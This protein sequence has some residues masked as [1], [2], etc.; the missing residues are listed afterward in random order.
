MNQ[1]IATITVEI[2]GKKVFETFRGPYKLIIYRRK[3]LL[4]I[5]LWYIIRDFHIW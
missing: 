4:N 5:T 2:F 1:I 3:V